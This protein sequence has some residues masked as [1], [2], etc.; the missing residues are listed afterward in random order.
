M[1][2]H[3][4]HCVIYWYLYL[5]Y[6]FYFVLSYGC[7]IVGYF[8][9]F[10]LLMHTLDSMGCCKKLISHALDE[11]KFLSD[12]DQLSITFECSNL[13]S[14]AVSW[15]LSVCVCV[16]CPTYI[17]IWSGTANVLFFEKIN[18][19]VYIYIQSITA[20]PWLQNLLLLSYNWRCVK[21]H[22]L[23]AAFITEISA[24]QCDH[25]LRT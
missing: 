21:H 12:V 14:L 24:L 22:I 6:L 3:C 7:R 16:C 19:D 23:T 8:I 10:I 17:H 18:K 25:T 1:A 4:N 9:L 11:M 13:Q 5:L 20:E 2:W 15:S